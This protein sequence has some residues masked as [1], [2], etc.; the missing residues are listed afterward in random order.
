[1]KH[2]YKWIKFDRSKGSDQKLPKERKYVLV[3][4]A[5]R[6]AGDVC[7]LP[8]CVAVGYLRY[9]GGD[10]NCPFF[11]IRGMGGPGFTVEYWCDC[12]GKNFHTPTYPRIS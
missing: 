10:F 1:M 3:Q 4:I 7:E 6:L 12:L 2:K 9:S 11:V 8:A 5:E